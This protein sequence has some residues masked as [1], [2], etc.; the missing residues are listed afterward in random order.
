MGWL[1]KG[2]GVVGTA[3]SMLAQISGH[4]N[5]AHRQRHPHMVVLL[6]QQACVE[7]YIGK[8]MYTYQVQHAV[9]LTLL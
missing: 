8:K 9:P 1:F 2:S 3:R 7:G 6:S 4:P 5:D